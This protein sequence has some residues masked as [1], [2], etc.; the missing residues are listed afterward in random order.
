MVDRRPIPG[1]VALADPDYDRLEGRLPSSPNLVF[2]D[3][4]DLETTLAR[5]GALRRVVYEH[6][7]SDRIAAFES[8]RGAS[9][10]DALIGLSA[11]LGRLRWLHQRAGGS[12][13]MDWLKPRRFVDERSLTLEY[14]DLQREAVKHGLAPSTAALQACLAELPEADPWQVARGHD[15]VE[16]VV[17][18]LRTRLGRWPSSRGAAEVASGLR[19]ALDRAEL[20]SSRMVS[21]IRAWE[22]AQGHYRVLPPV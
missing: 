12:V 17:V 16:V 10:E 6:G 11:E 18:A 13:G 14:E 3:A 4:R 15:L 21:E 9:V 22:K 2:T 19:L 7:Q 20:E 1:V 5:L 8:E